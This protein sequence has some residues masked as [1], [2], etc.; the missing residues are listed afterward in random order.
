MQHGRLDVLVLNAGAQHVSAIG[1]FRD[2]DWRRVMAV[3]LDGPFY[4]IRSAWKALIAAPQGR[5]IAV[6]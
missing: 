6:A 1:D 4:A 5:V 3:N 2:A